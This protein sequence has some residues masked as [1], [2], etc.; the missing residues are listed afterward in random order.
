VVVAAGVAGSVTVKPARLYLEVDEDGRLVLIDGKVA[1][2]L[3]RLGADYLADA[4]EGRWPVEATFGSQ[5]QRI[6][7]ALFA[8]LEEAAAWLLDRR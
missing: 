7:Q 1:A 6:G 3:S 5:L 4:H 8:D 2:A